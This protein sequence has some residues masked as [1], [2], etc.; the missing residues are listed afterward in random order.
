MQE[1]WPLQLSEVQGARD[2]SGNL[3]QLGQQTQEEGLLWNPYNYLQYLLDS[4]S[5]KD[6]T[7]TEF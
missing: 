5:G 7:D 3:L 2:T 4:R 6:T 1:Q